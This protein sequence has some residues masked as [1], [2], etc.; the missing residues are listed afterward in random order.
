MIFLLSVFVVF[1]IL[2]QVFQIFYPELIEGL[3]SNTTASTTATTTST[4]QPYD[5]SNP[6][7]VMILAQQNA[8]NISALKQQFD[9]VLGLNKQV[10]DLSGNF[11]TL[12]DQVNGIVMSQQQ[13]AS[14]INGGQPP[15][16]TGAT[17][18][19]EGFS[20][21]NTQPMMIISQ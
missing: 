3:E 21:F 1:L 11:V 7:N 14:Q 18:T 2:Y 5:M 9:Q 13:Y 8:G 4:Y 15:V 12:Q 16:I 17:T 20:L 19:T 10:Q 6:D